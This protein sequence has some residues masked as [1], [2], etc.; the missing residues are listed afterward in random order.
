[1]D[2]LFKKY[3]V[4]APRYTSYPTVPYWEDALPDS[5]WIFDLQK[6]L[7]KEESSWSLYI[8]IPFCESLCTYCGC[9]TSIT[10]NHSVEMPYVQ[11][12]LNEWE[13]YKKSVP[14][15]LLRELKEIHLGGGTPTFLS[16]Q[17]L[18]LL[19]SSIIRD[20]N[21]SRHFEGSIEVDPRKT[22]REQLQTLY[23]LGFTRV[24]LGVQDFNH[25]VQE[26]VNRI[27]PF[28]MTQKITDSAREIG[29]TSVNF[30]LIYGMP[31]QTE[32]H[33]IYTVQKTLELRPDRIALYSMAMVPWIKPAQRKFKDSDVPQGESKRKLYE[34]SRNMLIEAG[35]IEIGMDHFALPADSLALALENETLHRNFMGYT[36]LRTDVLL[37]LGV[38]SISESP[39]SFHQNEKVLP[40]YEQ[41]VSSLQIPTLRGH[42]LT[43]EDQ[44]QREIILNLM[45]KWNC[46]ISNSKEWERLILALEPL[47]NDDLLEMKQHKVTVREKGKPFLRNICMAFDLRL[48]RNKPEAKLFSQSL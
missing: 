17:S 5:K 15:F 13:L 26:I 42:S 29:Y 8:H 19:I 18:E 33:I 2:N 22:T 25:D 10:R 6:A 36:P 14:D 39:W 38:S 21:V 28:E 47:V 35:Y 46:E 1:M 12:L 23:R 24:S 31:L 37:G 48:I 41:K 44:D 11:S 20:T 43:K 9:N 45:T 32:N 27:Q 34:I 3:D 40:L 4:P 16:P 30:D 7:G